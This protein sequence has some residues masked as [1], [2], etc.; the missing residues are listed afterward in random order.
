LKV[1]IEKLLGCITK[2]AKYIVNSSFFVVPLEH[3]YKTTLF[4]S[5]YHILHLIYEYKY[6]YI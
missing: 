3:L 2:R 4:N 6:K 1:F 5:F